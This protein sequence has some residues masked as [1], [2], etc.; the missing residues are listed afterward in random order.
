[1]SIEKAFAIRATPEEIYA[2]IERDLGSA[3]EHAG[4][5][6]EVL[7]RDPG[8]SID[9]RV[10]IGGVPCWLTY[11]LEGKPDHTEVVATLT[12]FGFKYTFFRLITFGLHDQGFALS[13]VQGLTN[14]KEAVEGNAGPRQEE[15]SAGGVE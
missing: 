10:T 8:R 13:L 15:A 1:M 5:T 12:P 11:T 3:S 2:A 14:L 6:F 9:L 7:R 4:Q